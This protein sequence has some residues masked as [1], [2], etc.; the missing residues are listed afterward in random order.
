M[1]DD[2]EQD[3]WSLYEVPAEPISQESIWNG[4]RQIIDLFPEEPELAASTRADKALEE[5]DL[6]GFA[7]WSRITK[8]VTELVRGKPEG[9][10]AIN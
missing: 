2:D 3:V 7:L 10:T 1:P 6:A 9:P 5:G 8:A 4:A